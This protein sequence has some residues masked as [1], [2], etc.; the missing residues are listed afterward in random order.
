MQH[1]VD[2]V[3]GVNVCSAL[4]ELRSAGEDIENTTERIAESVGR[5]RDKWLKS[6]N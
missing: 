5:A 4:I 2:V 6:L 3:G 1:H